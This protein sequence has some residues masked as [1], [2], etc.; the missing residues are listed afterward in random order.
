MNNTDD[1]LQAILI[2]LLV[3]TFLL[4]ACR[5]LKA[6]EV[7]K[8]CLIF[9]NNTALK[10]EG[11]IFNFLH[12]G[13]YKTIVR[14]YCLILNHTN[15]LIYGRRLLDIYQ[16]CGKKVEEGNLVV[17][18]ADIYRQQY[19]EMGDRKNEAY[20]AERV[21]IISY[22]LGD[23]DRAKEYLKKAL[24]IRIQIADK[25]GE[26]ADYAHLGTVFQS[27]GEYNKAK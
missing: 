18:L 14:A 6:I 11:E 23:Y 15:A 1:I 12:I 19:E 27:L 13:I 5:G 4:N 3:A 21:G 26:A 9:L 2:G 8:E 10:P 17:E 16:K 7:C 24:A 22:R 20:T 25:K